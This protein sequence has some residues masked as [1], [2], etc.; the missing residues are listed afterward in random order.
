MSLPPLL[1][2][3]FLH[4]ELCPAAL[5]S[6]LLHLWPGLPNPQEGFHV[7]SEYPLTPQEAAH[8]LEQARNL[9]AAAADDMPAHSLLAAEKQARHMGIAKE[10]RDI[11]SF[12]HGKE[13]ETAADVR[14]STGVLILIFSILIV[15]YV[16]IL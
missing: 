11:S 1:F 6:S 3:P 8:Y 13:A 12:A 4:K 2:M 16:F 14:R 9:H 10:M 7:P 5:P 15:C